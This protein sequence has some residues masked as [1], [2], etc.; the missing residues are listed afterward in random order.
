MPSVSSS[1]PAIAPMTN[2]FASKCFML[3]RIRL[4]MSQRCRD[5][6]HHRHYDEDGPELLTLPARHEPSFGRQN[7]RTGGRHVG[8]SASYVGAWNGVDDRRLCDDRTT[9]QTD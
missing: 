4:N 7:D 2:D 1:A 6:P 8:R 9:C 3:T 5:Q